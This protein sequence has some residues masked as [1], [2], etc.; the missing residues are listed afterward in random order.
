MS[1]ESAAV[2]LLLEHTEPESRR[3]GA[4]QVSYLHGREG[5]EL[6]RQ[7]LADEDWRVRKEA[8]SVAANMGSREEVLRTLVL[9]L[10]EKENIGLRNAAVEALVAIGTEAVPAAILALETLDADGRKLAVEVLAGVPDARGTEALVGR[11]QDP[12]PNVRCAVAEA[13]GNASAAGHEARASAV[14]AL[15]AL[16]LSEVETLVKL[17][18]LGALVH[19]GAK[20]RWSMLAPLA[21]NVTL[22]RLAFAAA[23]RSQEREAVVA[24]ALA[25][26]DA[27][28]AVSMVALLALVE[29]LVLAEAP[30][31]VQAAR[32]VFTGPS[33]ASSAARDRIRVHASSPDAQIRGAALVALG[34]M[35]DPGDVTLLVEA[36]ADEEV[37]GRAEV[38]LRLFGEGAVAPMLEVGRRSGLPLRAATISLV[39]LLTATSDR[40]TREALHEALHDPAPD[41]LAAAITTIASTGGEGDLERVAPFARHF[42]VRVARTARAALYTLASRHPSEAKAL[43]ARLD[44]AGG[45]AAVG[46]VLLAALAETGAAR[47]VDEEDIEFLGAAARHSDAETRRAAVEALAAIG[48]E[49][50]A[51]VVLLAVADEESEV[52]VAAIRALGRMGRAEPLVALVRTSHDPALVAT[53]LRALAEASPAQAYEAARP[54]LSSSDPAVAC[55]AVGAIGGLAHPGREDGLF[56]ALG[57]R[58]AEVVKSALFELSRAPGARS[59]TRF[60][61]CLDHESWEVRRV[62]A[63][64]LGQDGGASARALLRAGLEREKDAL[65]REA[66]TSALAAGGTRSDESGDAS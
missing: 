28:P 23:A 17:A 33:A 36:L 51:E 11:L 41:V 53:A 2:R 24:L 18:A 46:C 16:V 47:K 13:L 42:D 15:T 58:D 34:T 19:L 8:A 27:S 55:A 52:N 30:E 50:A 3:L 43:R 14:S 1:S 37:S 44:A 38:G 54:L 63:E 49:A 31:L 65:V 32:E 26:A 60:G 22:R 5:A 9:A 56:E 12:D 61:T 40:P 7:A 45:D 20:L 29:C 4:Q 62:A 25:T 59:L 10:D 35:R 6:L 48:G 64:V 57:H 39:P 66:I 21:S